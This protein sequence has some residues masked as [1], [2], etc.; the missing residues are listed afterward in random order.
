MPPQERGATPLTDYLRPMISIADMDTGHGGRPAVMRLTKLMVE[1]GAAGVH[2]KDQKPGTKKCGH[3][4]GKVLVSTR[5]H[6]DCLVATRLQ[7]DSS[8]VVIVAP[9]AAYSARPIDN[10]FDPHDQPLHYRLHQHRPGAVGHHSG[11]PPAPRVPP[12]P[13]LPPL[14]RSAA[15][16]TPSW[17][18]SRPPTCPTATAQARWLVDMLAGPRFPTPRCALASKL[19]L[20]TSTG[21]GT[22]LA[23]EGYY[24][25][26]GGIDFCVSRARAFSEHADLIWMETSKPDLEQATEFSAKLHS[27]HPHQMLAYNLP[28]SFNWDAAGLSDAEITAFPHRARTPGLLLAVHHSRRLSC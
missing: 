28:P 9:T 2:I 15:T 12:T 4:G 18:R 23:P 14:L 20:A 17:L 26:C 6:V 19:A 24:R 13:S 25:T 22:R 8:G 16:K 21:T 3:M 11:R 7:A 1:A 27:T 10:N 5:D